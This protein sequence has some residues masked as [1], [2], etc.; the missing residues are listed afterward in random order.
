M[1]NRGGR[2]GN[3]G[4]RGGYGGN[5]Q[6]GDYQGGS[7]SQR[8]GHGGASRGGYNQSGGSSAVQAPQADDKLKSI[9]I[10]TLD[11]E[12]VSPSKLMQKINNIVPAAPGKA[13]TPIKLFTNHSPVQLGEG[14]YYQYSV[15]FFPEVESTSRTFCVIFEYFIVFY[16]ANEFIFCLLTFHKRS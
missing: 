16:N 6:G 2:G 7:S 1:S 3:R 8:G 9:A 4:G 11:V 10:Q 14:P 15:K 13:G 5:S 12:K